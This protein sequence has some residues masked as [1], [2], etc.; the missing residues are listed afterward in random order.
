[1]ETL[2]FNDE[3]GKELALMHNLDGTFALTAGSP[4]YAPDHP[5]TVPPLGIMLEEDGLCG[6]SR[7]EASRLTGPESRQL[8]SDL[9]E[10]L[11]YV[12][13]RAIEAGRPDAEAA[14]FHLDALRQ[15]L[16]A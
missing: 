4:D 16:N 2:F 13:E 3:A 10:A 6:T 12:V 1:L 9:C 7:E 5:G 15:S 11:G 8:V 14:P